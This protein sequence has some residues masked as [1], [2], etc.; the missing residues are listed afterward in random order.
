MRSLTVLGLLPTALLFF[1]RLGDRDLWGSHEA[2]A[3][4]D[5]Q[6]VLDRGEW[7]IPRLF[8]DR[9]EHQKPPLY[10]W[11]VAAAAW[12]RG[13]PVDAVAVRLP[14]ALAGMATVLAVYGF[15]AARGRSLAGVLAATVL[16]TAQHFTW[17]ARTGRIDVPL[18]FAVAGAVL[19]LWTGRTGALRWNLAG[20]LFVSAGV[21]LK[22][23]LGLILPFIILA[24]DAVMERWCSPWP[25]RGSWRPISGRMAS[26]P[27]C[28][29][30]TTTS[31]GR[32]AGR[33]PWRPTRG[34]TT[35]RGSRATSCRGAWCCRRPGGLR[36]GGPTRSPGS[37]CCG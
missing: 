19:C 37:A 12:L 31:S 27:A 13:R 33:R 8:D 1:Y 7:V 17:I 36:T 34:G 20:Y 22:G 3:G 25:G 28:F 6:T 5:A 32:R 15:L 11:S 35:P 10:Y 14:A 9:P 16:A 29:S 30:G 21:L 18:T 23:P 2:R 24:A 4:Q 26:S